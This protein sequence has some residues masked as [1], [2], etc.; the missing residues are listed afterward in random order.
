MRILLG[1]VLVALA[2]GACGGGNDSDTIQVPEGR[3]WGARFSP[4][5]TALAVAFG[6]DDRIGVYD[7]AS[8]TLTELATG[9]TYLTG[10]AWSASGDTIYFDGTVGVRSV[11][12]A[13][14][15]V[16]DVNAAFASMNVDLSPDGTRLAYGVN[17]DLAA[18]YTIATDSETLLDRR[19]QAIRFAPDGQR[20]A[21]VSS[22]ALVVIELASGTATTVLPTGVPFIAG[23]DWYNDGQR[24]L[25]TTEDGIEAVTLAGERRMVVDAFAAVELDLSPDE[26]ELVYRQNG[27]DDLTIVGL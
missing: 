18:V 15:A 16:T 10:T 1:S 23:V 7:R 12:R 2:L 6:S 14:G 20:V 25:V 3:L 24:L 13:G 8:G 5:G 22:G 19:C 21:C 11:P 17:G 4:D 26:R 27:H 9:T